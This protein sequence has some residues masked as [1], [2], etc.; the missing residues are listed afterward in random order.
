MIKFDKIVNIDVE[1][2]SKIDIDLA[3][4]EGSS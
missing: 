1:I 4:Y 3:K 2:T